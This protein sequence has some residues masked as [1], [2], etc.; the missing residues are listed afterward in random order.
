MWF[1]DVLA[2]KHMDSDH[3]LSTQ[4]F[5]IST[6]KGIQ[7]QKAIIIKEY[8]INGDSP[9]LNIIYDV[10]KES[11]GKSYT[12]VLKRHINKYE[13]NYLSSRT[14]VHKR[15]KNDIQLANVICGYLTKEQ[16]SEILYN[17]KINTQE[18]EKLREVKKFDNQEK[19][20]VV[21]KCQLFNL[22]L[23]YYKV[24]YQ[25][26][27]IFNLNLFKTMTMEICQSK[28]LATHGCL[29]NLK[30]T[31]LNLEAQLSNTGQNMKTYLDHIF[32]DFS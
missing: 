22:Y 17:H 26:T 18:L 7:Y 2:F 24:N 4:Q 25:S 5:V 29:K 1:F 15:I 23:N 27:S 28:D 9:H 20:E 3:Q 19:A 12:Q 31:F 13:R 21:L 8:G 16:N 6:L 32:Y 11:H 10:I 30:E 14:L